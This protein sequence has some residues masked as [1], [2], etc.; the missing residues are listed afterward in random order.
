MSFV[1]LGAAFVLIM[2]AVSAA[3]NFTFGWRLGENS[4]T[5]TALFH[6]GWIYG[7]L[8]IASDGFKIC[9]GV[10]TV[11]ILL[12]RNLHVLLRLAG[13]SLC[14]ILF[15]AAT[16]YSLNSAIGTISQNRTDM[17]GLRQAKA[18]NYDAIEKQL[19]RVQDEQSWLDQ[20]YRAASAIEADISG[21]R[22]SHLWA[23]T[24]GCA[25]ATVPESRTFCQQYYGLGAELGTARRAESLA[26]RA[27]ELRKSLASS[28]GKIIADPHAKMLNDLT[29][30]GEDAIVLAWLLLVVALVE[31]GSTLGPIVIWLARRAEQ[32]REA[33]KAQ[34]ASVT[35][36]APRRPAG[37]PQHLYTPVPKP[38]PEIKDAT[39][40]DTPPDGGGTPKPEPA[41]EKPEPEEEK[42]I[43]AT[44]ENVITLAPKADVPAVPKP[45][46]E[47][48][49][50]TWLSA[51]TSQ[52][53][54]R[55][56]K[57]TITDCYRSYQAW[58]QQH[59]FYAISKRALSREVAAQLKMPP[60][61]DGPRNKGGRIFPRLLV[62]MPADDAR[63]KVA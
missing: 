51:C 3:F 48:K 12:S 4:H 55:K 43:A 49:T 29:G 37:L 57:T 63:R 52:D 61:K 46:K 44:A 20:K 7:Q 14:G 45:K 53:H 1:K 24:S 25:D 36:L 35:P 42:P 18:T 32:P 30:Y 28:G 34:T 54:T 31:G 5:V 62:Y 16:T 26:S 39:T 38:L 19:V 8:S 10:L 59:G 21:M 41:P 60:S 56:R 47:G 6:D 13:A 2:V 15:V 27:D 58:C 40:P 17:A 9:L 50:K 23:R 33:A 11:K 22:Q